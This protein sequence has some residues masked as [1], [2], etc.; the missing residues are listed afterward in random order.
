MGTQV[1]M[2]RHFS[3]P[4]YI[5]HELTLYFIIAVCLY[6]HSQTPNATSFYAQLAF[7][8]EAVVGLSKSL[9]KMLYSYELNSYIWS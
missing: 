4:Y 7:R 5:N 6:T 9:S 1:L 3:I 2:M 8:M